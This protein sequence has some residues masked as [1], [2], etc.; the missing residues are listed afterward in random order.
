M[1]PYP[2]RRVNIN[3]VHLLRPGHYDL[4]AHLG[5]TH[6]MGV[7]HRCTGLDKVVTGLGLQRDVNDNHTIIGFAMSCVTAPGQGAP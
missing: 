4:G 2:E 5:K 6:T 1:A 3:L 7:D